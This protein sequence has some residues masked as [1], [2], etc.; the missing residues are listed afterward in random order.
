MAWFPSTVQSLRTNSWVKPFPEPW[1]TTCIPWGMLLNI[2]ETQFPHMWKG[3]NVLVSW[4]TGEGNGNP[5]QYSCL[6]NSMDRGAC[7]TTVHA[8][9]E[10]DTTEQLTHILGCACACAK[11][12]QSCPTPCDPVAYS[13]SGS[14]VHGILQTGILEWATMPSRSRDHT[15]ASCAFCVGRWILLI[16]ASP[17]KPSECI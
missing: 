7:Q 16:L 4:A 12:L 17:G 2:S 1:S 9:A 15:G 8:A 13:P 3:N 10:S 5:V 11:S 14:S 6:E